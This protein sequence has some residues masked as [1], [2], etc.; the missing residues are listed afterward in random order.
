MMNSNPKI[1]V[2]MS[3]YNEEKY[4]RESL[5][6]LQNQT[7]SDFEV[8]IIDDCSIDS[9]REIIKELAKEDSRFHLFENSEN[10]GLTKNLNYALTL[11]NGSYIARMDGDDLS[12]PTRFAT[13]LRY[14]EA[15]PQ[16]KL[17]SCNTKTFGAIN[18]VSDING[19]PSNVK[20]SMLLRPQ[21]AHPG[22]MMKAELVRDL[23]FTYDEHFR[24]AQDYDFAWR[25]SRKYDIAVT[26]EYLLRYRTHS[27]QV[28]SVSGG[29]QLAFADEIRQRGLAELGIE[30]GSGITDEQYASYRL[31]AQEADAEYSDFAF[32]KGLIGTILVN[33]S[34]IRIYDSS[35]LEKTL[36][37]EFFRWVF[38]SNGKKY[39]LKLCGAD[40]KS[41]GDI[42]LLGAMCGTWCKLAI[43]KVRRKL[44]A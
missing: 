10:R 34:D 23:G 42:K 13:Q 29:K 43:S 24:S 30:L 36:W 4:I 32:C 17:V 16:V 12:E 27:A 15:H 2:I 11:T 25:V 6:S 40:T 39:A 14:L 41:G 9:T 37:L 22:F 35:V 38:R 18:L 3:V 26:P 8:I 7:E 19:N 31:W 20:C 5:G 28:S 33:N 1:S 21:L 44:M